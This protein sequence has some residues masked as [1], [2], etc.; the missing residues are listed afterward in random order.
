ML[1]YPIAPLHFGSNHL[2]WTFPISRLY[3]HGILKSKWRCVVCHSVSISSVDCYSYSSFRTCVCVYVYDGYARTSRSPLRCVGCRVE[4]SIFWF[5]T[6]YSFPLPCDPTHC[7]RVLESV[8][9]TRSLALSQLIIQSSYLQ[10]S[11]LLYGTQSYSWG[12]FVEPLSE[13]GWLLTERQ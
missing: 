4:S 2:V 10:D 1:F 11:Y 8:E 9:L 6:E 3:I 13:R 7:L 12:C 5:C